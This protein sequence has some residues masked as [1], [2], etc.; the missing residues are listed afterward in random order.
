[1]PEPN[2]NQPKGAPELPEE[3]KKLLE[4]QGD[5]SRQKQAEPQNLPEVME[6]SIADQEAQLGDEEL[7][8]SDAEQA[9][10]GKKH[11]LRAFFAGYWR[12]KKW[13]L[14]L[15]LLVLVG[16][17]LAVPATRYPVLGTFLTSTY[18]IEVVDSKTGTPVSGATV[19]L[20]G[21]TALTDDDGHAAIRAHVGSR[22]LAI[23][24]KYY[25]TVRAGAFVGIKSRPADSNRL[26]LVATGRQVPLKVI[27]KLSGKPVKNA[28]IRVLDTSAKTD[29][30]GRAIIVLPTT[31]ATE[32]ATVTAAGYNQAGATVRVTNKTVPGNT[33]SLTPA[34]RVYFLS[35]A[36]GTIDVV[37]TNLDGAAR[38]TVL[39]GTGDE[40][41]DHTVLLASRDWKYLALLS[42]RDGGQHAK[43]FLIQT[44]DGRVTTMDEDAADFTPIGWS[45]HHFV[46][47]VSRPD[48]PSWKP[49]AS[50]INSYDADQGEV[51]VLAKSHASGTDD[52]S[53]MYEDLVNAVLFNGNLVYARTWH[54]Y[55]GYFSA[56][57][58]KNVLAT[59]HPDGSGAATLKTLNAADA[60][61]GNLTIPR[62]D[63]LYFVVYGSAASVYYELGANGSVTHRNTI[64]AGDF[65]KPYP[66]YLESPAGTRTLWMEIRDGKNALLVGGRSGDDAKEIARLSGYAPYGWYTDK[67]VLLQKD[68]SELYVMQ[69]AGGKPVKISDYYKSARKF[70]GYGGGYGGL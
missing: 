25:T 58:K 31:H 62:P 41:S 43:L 29:E 56:P 13:A 20:D 15:T 64:T 1:M 21:R 63:K 50:S 30:T 3:S 32:K 60:Y 59:V 23:S 6:P 55:P 69:A 8:E 46:Y 42:R 53:A 44:A 37:S 27:D 54:Q 34:G 2:K 38:K 17:L 52:A 22:E 67:Y 36:S 26:K 14:P 10:A 9:E 35:N 51:V 66:T 48:I 47:R 7:E 68:D 33:I 12:H 4:D 11:R 49:N 70:Y 5:V 57:G 28:K 18:R 16:G 39:A 24:K 61:F 40:D 45:G 19:Q 65:N